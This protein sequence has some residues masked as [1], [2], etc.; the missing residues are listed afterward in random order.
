MTRLQRQQLYLNGQLLSDSHAIVHLVL[1]P[2]QACAG[3]LLIEGAGKLLLAPKN[4]D[5]TLES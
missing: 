4:R 5:V 2:P 1:E 3:Y